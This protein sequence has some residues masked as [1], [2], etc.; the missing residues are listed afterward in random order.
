MELGGK[1]FYRR[2]DEH[3]TKMFMQWI[4]PTKGSVG[5]PPE[6]WHPNIKKTA[7]ISWQQAVVK[8]EERKRLGLS[9]HT[10]PKMDNCKLMKKKKYVRR[11]YA[12][13]NC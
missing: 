3:W 12:F 8:I 11:L 4:P 9:L 1:H 5:R 2:T 10:N 6:I 7:A 13:S